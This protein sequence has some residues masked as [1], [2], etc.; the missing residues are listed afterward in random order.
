[1]GAVGLLF[2]GAVLFINGAMLLGW[3]DAKSAAP[4]NFFVGALQTDRAPIETEAGAR[5]TRRIHAFPTLGLGGY[6]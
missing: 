5:A 2:V 3:V 1:V 6:T 4:I